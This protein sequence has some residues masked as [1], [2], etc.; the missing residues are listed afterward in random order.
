V[1][2]IVKV[3]PENEPPTPGG[4]SVIGTEPVVAPVEEV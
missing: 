1:P 3:L 4:K 2:D